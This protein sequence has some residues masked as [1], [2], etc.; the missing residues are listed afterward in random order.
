MNTLTETLGH[1]CVADGGGTMGHKCNM[2]K[3][4]Y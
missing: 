4:R 2:I 1:A 3:T